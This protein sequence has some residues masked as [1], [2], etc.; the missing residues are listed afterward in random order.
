LIFLEIF[1]LFSRLNFFKTLNRLILLVFFGC[2]ILSAQDKDGHNDYPNFF[3]IEFL[4]GNTI[5]PSNTSPKTKNERGFMVHFGNNNTNNKTDWAS[6]L[7]FPRTGLTLGMID[8]GN[9][10]NIGYSISAMPFIET[11]VLK[12]KNLFLNG[13]LGVSF[14]TKKYQIITNPKNSA[15]TTDLNWAFRLFFHYQLITTNKINWRIG[16]GYMHQSNGHFRL[17]NDG[18]NSIFASTSVQ[19]NYK[20]KNPLKAETEDIIQEKGQLRNT[21]V[22]FRTGLGANVFSQRIN[23]PKA[24]YTAAFSGGMVY[25]NIIKYSAGFYYRYY[26][27]YYH[28]IIS[29]GELINEEYAHFKENPYKYATNFGVF[30]SAELL[31]SHIGIEFGIGYNIFKPFYAIDRQVGQATPYISNGQQYY[32][33]A[34]LNFEYKLKQSFS[35]RLGL[36]YYLFSTNEAHPYNFFI[37]GHINANL[38]QA[39]FNELSV[40]ILY[41]FNFI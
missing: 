20:S 13:A 12:I 31:L 26:Q 1:V 37:G 25:N 30:V 35:S 6:R 28:Y 29:E 27:Q 33:N 11:N 7:G 23:T 22:S 18:L 36:K 5:P 24:I 4:G 40:G 39:D 21:F 2:Q 34:D 16:L 9:P 41:N 8:Y 19:L 38:W 14:L 3:A 10:E 15:I 17:P 32:A